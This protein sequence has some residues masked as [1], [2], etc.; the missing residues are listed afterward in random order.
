MTIRNS[1]IYSI[2]L[3]C[4]AIFST[5]C[6]DTCESTRT[7]IY[8]EPVYI[9][10]QVARE[11]FKIGDPIVL[12]NPGKIYLYGQYV[13]INEPGK[14]VHII[15]NIDKTNP[16]IEKFISIPGN[17]D[18]AVKNNILY[19]D[20]YVDLLS[21]DISDLSNIK[22]IN[23]LEGAFPNYNTQFGFA[24][25]NGVVI[26]RW[27]EIQ[28]IEIS[29]DCRDTGGVIIALEF[30]VAMDAQATAA[31]GPDTQV[32]IGGSL[33]RFAVYLDYLYAVDSYS[34][35]IFDIT[36]SSTPEFENAVDISWDVETLFPFKDKL[37]I[38]AQ[39]GMYIFDV[40]VPALP[41]YVSN[42][43]HVTACDPVVANDEFAFVTL[44][45][46]NPCQGFTNELDVIDIRNITTPILR[47]IYPMENP[48]GLGL[49][50]NI[51]F[52][53]EGDF[54]LKV[55]DISD[56]DNITSNLIAH[57]EDIRAFDVIPWQKVLLAIGADGL[58]QYDYSDI[59]NIKLLSFIP[60]VA[61]EI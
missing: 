61:P 13:L 23:R 31:S 3:G 45:S 24:A 10:T 2:V 25:E 20:S 9:T 17:F 36:E 6:V 21:I 60:V 19:A 43:L 39:S 33:A 22:L 42:F 53:C 8:F 26:S 12:E 49:D 40:S 51:L 44:R 34:L 48:Y 50:E 16:V 46:G 54:G 56:V 11:G 18:I 41:E 58:Y 32:G 14:G 38:G 1:I 37:F 27:E 4:L 5:A 28:G 59:Q 55:F 30:G 29:N 35:N 47:K 7:Y 15:N 52:L 57:F